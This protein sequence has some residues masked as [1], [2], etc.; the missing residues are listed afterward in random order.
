MARMNATTARNYAVERLT[1]GAPPMIILDELVT[2][3]KIKMAPAIKALEAAK[4]IIHRNFDEADYQLIRASAFAGDS[5]QQQFYRTRI[6]GLLAMQEELKSD[7]ALDVEVRTRLVLGCE[8]QMQAW[9]T[10]SLK[11]RQGLPTAFAPK[12]VLQNQSPPS[13][14]EISSEI[15]GAL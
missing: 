10:L 1:D 7:D 9:A 15:D 2:D 13:D 4:G 11:G 5:Y 6:D 3:K 14:E 12:G 8:R